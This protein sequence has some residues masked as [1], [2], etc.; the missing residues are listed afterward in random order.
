MYTLKAW[1]PS[2]KSYGS[3]ID[4]YNLS[5]FRGQNRRDPL[6]RLLKRWRQS[7]GAENHRERISQGMEKTISAIRDANDVA[8]KLAKSLERLAAFANSVCSFSLKS[9]MELER[10]LESGVQ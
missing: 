2:P 9:V 4:L 6:C 3:D 1:N 10:S 7:V 8:D 5:A